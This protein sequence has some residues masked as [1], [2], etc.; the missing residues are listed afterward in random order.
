MNSRTLITALSFALIMGVVGCADTSKEDTGTSSTP[1]DPTTVTT[2][3][4]SSATDTGVPTT[5]PTTT[6]TPGD[7]S[8]TGDSA[9]STSLPTTTDVRTLVMPSDPHIQYLGRWD[10][11]VPDE[12][13]CGWAGC[14][15]VVNFE[16]TGLQATLNP[17]TETEYF[18]VIVDDDHQ[19]ST[20]IMVSPGRE[21]YDLVD[22]LPYRAHK[23]ELVK[24]TYT[25]EPTIFQR[26]GVAGL[27]LL[28]PPSPP[29][30]RILF[31][32]D[33]TLVGRSLEHE[34]NDLAPDVMGSHFGYAG[35]VSRS[36]DA[37]YHKIA[38]DDA[39]LTTMLD[40]MGRTD[41]DDP[42]SEW[43]PAEFQAEAVV[44]QL[45]ANDVGRLKDDIVTDYRELIL[46][47]RERQ[48]DAHIVLFNAWG[49]NAEEP[50]QYT[51]SVVTFMDDEALSSATFP[52]L[53][54]QLNGCEYDHGGMAEHL[55]THLSSELGWEAAPSDVMSGF[56]SGGDVA[57]GGFEEVAPFG[58][59]GW[60]YHEAPETVRVLDAA[61][62]WEGEAYVHLSEGGNLHQPNPVEP[63]QVITFTAWMRGTTDADEA[64]VSL[65]FRPGLFGAAPI[66]TSSETW[67]LT[68][69]WASYVL[70]ATAPE[71]VPFAPDPSQIRVTVTARGVSEV[72][73]DGLEMVVNNPPITTTTVTTTSPTGTTTGTDTGLWPDDTGSSLGGDTG[74]FDPS[75]SSSDDDT[76]IP[77]DMDSGTDSAGRSSG[78]DSSAPS[79]SEDTST[80]DSGYD[81]DGDDSAFL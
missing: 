66:A 3:T 72:D 40:L 20:K 75:D 25:G 70:E 61:E 62:A 68:P 47:V 10:R 4:S 34:R 1:T 41:R 53:F 81:L 69:E 73:V 79:P 31:L 28:P 26:F 8:D 24:E 48:P 18:R 35:I 2:D 6:S 60:R 76:S 22:G 57:N 59:F 63:G 17:G 38:L 56:G 11:S 74:P 77:V 9:T 44:V 14:S 45:G 52:R 50:S 46:A 30:R 27:D 64:T 36:F 65:D 55:I 67:S 54:E 37:E 80:G 71:S 16:G 32:G 5:N 33:Q 49:W 39:T 21:T 13:W 23:V 29:S 7:T 58:G 19:N 78:S 51:A 15:V 43:D 42:D 12:P